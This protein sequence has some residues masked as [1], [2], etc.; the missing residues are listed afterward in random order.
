MPTITNA[1]HKWYQEIAAGLTAACVTLP[2]SLSAGVLVYS[3]MGIG[4]L[5]QGAAAGILT[6]VVAGVLAAMLATSSFIITGPLASTSI[7]PAALTA[8]LADRQPFAHEPNLIISAIA[9]CVLLAGL[10]QV[11]FSLLGIERIIKFAPHSV[12][13]GF[14]NSIGLIIILS[15]LRP[16]ISFDTT[17]GWI[18]INHPTMLAFVLALTACIIVFGNWTKKVPAPLVGLFGGTI[19]YYGLR[20]P[21]PELSLGATIG[22]LPVVLPATLPFLNLEQTS[23]RDA[24]LSVTPDLVLTSLTLAVVAT[25]QALLA[26]RVAQ[27]LAHLPPRPARDLVAQ[28]IAN[29][30]SA[31]AGG[32]VAL[33]GTAALSAS[34]H[35]G[36]RTRWSGLTAAVAILLI[37]VFFSEILERIPVAVLSAILVSVGY[38]VLDRWTFKLPGDAIFKRPGIDRRHAWQNLSVVVLVMIVSVGG[39]IVAGAV[40]GFILSCLIFS[41]NMA[42]PIVRHAYF[43]HETFS[44]RARPS[45]DM[46][47]LRRAGRERA[48]LELQG[49]LFFGN[50]DAL[51]NVVD[52]ILKESKMVLLDVGGISDVDVSGASI[53]AN[54]MEQAHAQGKR[55]LLCN[56]RDDRLSKIVEAEAILPDVDS[57]LQWMEDQ[58]LLAAGTRTL[59]RAVA[60]ETHE[61]IQRLDPVEFAIFAAVLIARDFERGTVICSEGEDADRMW[62]LTKGTVSVRLGS[63]QGSRRVASFAAGATFGEM[64]LLENAAPRSASVIADED[65]STFELTRAAFDSILEAH[66]RIAVKLLKYFA[67]E[68]ARRLRTS[69]RDLRLHNK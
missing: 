23:T 8:Y 38:R 56:L 37:V 20:S 69:D 14:I 43:G 7:I 48:I 26:F 36:G 44:K 28:G 24:L 68:M 1:Q 53:L 63:E 18:A 42:R 9:L 29:C 4:F 12:I 32:I 10:L 47:I 15:Q 5:A 21:F 25:L 31:V 17:G 49:V 41:V 54:L 16:F 33:A 11:V 65:I 64:A 66:P 50:G 57:G 34:F 62:L 2:L 3:P 39:S 27:N 52:D 60:L 6:A 22:K 67:Q 13:A 51:S 35:A 46:V 30:G 45:D 55:I 59:A 61:L 19:I 58:A 40:A